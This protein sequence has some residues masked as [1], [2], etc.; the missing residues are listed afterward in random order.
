MGRDRHRLRAL[1]AISRVAGGSQ[2]AERL[3]CAE[4]P[5]VIR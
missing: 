4:A 1:Q 3:G 5:H 2:R